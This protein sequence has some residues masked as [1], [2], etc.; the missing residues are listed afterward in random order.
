MDIGRFRQARNINKDLWDWWLGD[1]P[2]PAAARQ[3]IRAQ[4]VR[5]ANSYRPRIAPAPPIAAVGS[6]AAMGE[7]R[8]V[9]IN[10]KLPKIQDVRLKAILNPLRGSHGKRNSTVVLSIL[11]LVAFIMLTNTPAPAAQ[12]TQPA[13]QTVSA[14]STKTT[15]TP[16]L[17]GNSPASNSSLNTAASGSNPSVLGAST[18]PSFVPVVPVNEPQL[19]KSQFGR[20]AY[21]SDAGIYTIVD[22]FDGGPVTINEKVAAQA[23]LSQVAAQINA[24]Q[25]IAL[26]G[27]G[28]AYI[29][30][31]GSGSQSA[32]F[33]L[34]GVTVVINSQVVHS[35]QDWKN[36]IQTFS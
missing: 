16:L 15:A 6:E 22:S 3:E 19:A 11:G 8:S 7:V 10:L 24:G 35:A 27:G 20:T 34:R 1:E 28:T 36:Y 33:S 5:Q 4:R 2:P 13:T 12:K 32:V 18:S 31:P 26:T 23:T 14:G 30:L 17:A 29:T 25:P 9:V 21:D